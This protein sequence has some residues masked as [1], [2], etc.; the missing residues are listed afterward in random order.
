[1]YVVQCTYT[2]FHLLALRPQM[3]SSHISQPRI[4]VRSSPVLWVWFFKIWSPGFNVNPYLIWLTQIHH[5]F[6]SWLGIFVLVLRLKKFYKGAIH[7]WC[8]PF[9]EMFD[10]SLPLITHFITLIGL[11]S[12]VTSWQ[13]PPKWVTSFMY[14]PNSATYICKR[15]KQKS[16]AHFDEDQL[17]K[18]SETA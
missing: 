7:K 2:I 14:G 15:S 13:I 18:S 17:S 11:W 4:S 12:N 16:S 3:Q 8:H 5:Y 10:P 9:F 6:C 1:M